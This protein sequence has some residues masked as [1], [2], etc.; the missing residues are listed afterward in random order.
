MESR[1]PSADPL[2]LV[3]D[4]STEAERLIA[5]LRARGFRVRDVPLLLLA[6]RVESQQPGLIVCDGEAPKLAD[7]LKRVRT[8]DWGK[9]ID[10]LL[11][12][13]DAEQLAKVLADTVDDL[14][15]HL[16]ARPIDVYSML[17]TIEERIGSPV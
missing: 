7:T 1:S 11:L 6:G 14:P 13:G 8:G 2:V 12:G 9:N 10:V 15:Q 17:Q 4:T 16:F 5:C 3:S